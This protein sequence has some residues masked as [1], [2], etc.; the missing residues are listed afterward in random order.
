MALRPESRR[1]KEWEEW[2]R[3]EI[4]AAPPGQRERMRNLLDGIPPPTPEME[5]RIREIKREV[6]RVFG[7]GPKRRKKRV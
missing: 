6:E 7:T 3:R 4:A 5:E 2:K 1:K